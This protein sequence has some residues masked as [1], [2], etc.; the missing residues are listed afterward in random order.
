MKID[1]SDL[2]SVKNFLAE[3]ADISATLPP[4]KTLV[5]NA[6]ILA[7]PG[8]SV[9]GHDICFA[10][11]H[12]GHFALTEGLLPTLRANQPSRIVIVSSDSH[13]WN[14][15]LTKASFDDLDALK[16]EMLPPKDK[17]SLSEKAKAYSYSNLANVLHMKDL[18]DC[19]TKNGITATSLH[20]G[21]CVTTD[22]ANNLGGFSRFFYKHIISKFSKNVNQGSSTTIYCILAPAE[23]VAGK[24]C[25]DCS[26]N[27]YGKIVTK[28]SSS[29]FHKFNESLMLA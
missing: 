29:Q 2:V 21:S 28:E 24:Y 16:Q 10:T 8:S 13:R 25:S 15:N 6:G 17:M 7:I 22:I 3:F 14:F 23:E 4:L 9:Q 19:E 11:K 20:P 12:L 1:T 18:Y 27:R 26:V 5:N